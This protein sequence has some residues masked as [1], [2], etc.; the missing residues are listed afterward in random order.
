MKALSYLVLFLLMVVTHGCAEEDHPYVGY[1]NV[2]L[3]VVDAAGGSTTITAD[4]DISDPILL[5]VDEADAE[6]C[7]VS[8]N[9]K[10][11]TATATKPNPNA[12]TRTATINVK[13]GYRITSFTVL[14]KYVG[15][16]YL[17]YD[18]IGSSYQVEPNNTST[19][20]ASYL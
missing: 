4:T 2:G 5:E 9:G 18:W 6:W 14:Q 15:Q 12:T 20:G 10:E 3:A 8:A 1:I 13:C 11:I 19:S 17:Q 7:T 16:E